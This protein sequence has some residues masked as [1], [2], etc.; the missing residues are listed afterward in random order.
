MAM[1]AT[2][3]VPF[4]NYLRTRLGLNG[5]DVPEPGEWADA[6]NTIGMLALRMNLL[7]VEQIDQIL[8]LQEKEGS[9]RRFGELAEALGLLS[10]R[11]VS[12]LLAIQALNRE[13]ELGERFVLS[14]R[15]E[16]SELV[17]H[18]HEFVNGAGDGRFGEEAN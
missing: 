4:V 16:V 11:Q 9:V 1:L 14:G 10:H 18:L 17:R 13:L 6:G 2:Q 8:E 7:T 5:S 3:N 12:R 15:M